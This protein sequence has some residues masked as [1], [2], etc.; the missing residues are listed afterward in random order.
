MNTHPLAL[1]LPNEQWSIR[2]VLL[3]DVH[4]L[5]E[6]CWPERTPVL[7]ERFIQ[8]IQKIQQQKRGLGVVALHPLDQTALGYGQLQLWARGAEISDLIVTESYRGRGIGTAIIQYLTR[9]ARTMGVNMVE[10]GASQNNPRAVKL[11]R[12]LG[13]R[14]H[15]ITP[16]N[17]EGGKEEI[18]YLRLEV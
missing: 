10:I 3:A 9:T 5:Y 2:P 8:R 13:F 15:H 4:A 14:D 1:Q 12:H 11:Y 6:N 17:S 7:V 18:L 16:I